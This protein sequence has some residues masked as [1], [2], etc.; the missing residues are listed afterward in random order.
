[1]NNQNA[2]RYIEA[3]KQLEQAVRSVYRLKESDSISY[4][5]RNL[6]EFSQDAEEIKY[7]QEVRNLLQHRRKLSDAYPVQPADEM[8]RFLEDLTARVKKRPLCLDICISFSGLYW[9]GFDGSVLKTLQ[10]MRTRGFT[11]VPI[12][13]KKRVAGVFDRTSLF[14]F[15]ADQKGGGLT[16]AL[17]FADIRDYLSLTK[18]RTEVFTFHPADLYVDEL[19]DVFE[20]QY[21][22]GR[23]ISAA[24][25]T[26]E[27]N[28][29]EPIIG[30][31]TP[32]DILGKVDSW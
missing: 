22:K 26:A 18:R 10:D 2:E 27:G 25:L 24:F 31:I 29:A 7:C 6:R 1:M 4:Y 13:E 16:E 17:T 9:R 8:I 23:R 28:A 32:W 11:Q 12:L 30:M 19:Q 21:K 3:Y 20:A 15:L 5:L 14:D